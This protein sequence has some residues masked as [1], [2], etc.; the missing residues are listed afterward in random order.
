MIRKLDSHLINQIAAGEVI[1]RPVSVV[2]ELVENSID[3]GATRIQVNLDFE[4]WFSLEV[5][6]NGCWIDRGDLPLVFEKHATSK[7][8]SLEDLQQVLTFGFRGEAL[9]SIGSVSKT[10]VV[11]GTAHSKKVFALDS[12]NQK[13]EEVAGEVGTRVK[14]EDLFYNTPARLHYLKKEKT[15]YGHIVDYIEKIALT[16]PELSFE[17]QYNGKKVLFFWVKETLDARLYQIFG[18][19]IAEKALKI[20]MELSGLRISGR[21]SHPTQSFGNKNKQVLSVNTRIISSPIIYKALSD[22]YNRYIAPRTFPAYVLNIELDPT[23]IDVN[24]HPRKQELRFA[25][26]GGIFRLVYQSISQ[27]LEKVSLM[28]ENGYQTDDSLSFQS[29]QVSSLSSPTWEN[30]FTKKEDFYTG[31]WT[32]FKG[33][34]PYSIRTENPNQGKVFDSLAFS[35]EILRSNT[36]FL[37]SEESQDNYDLHETPLWRI[38]WQVHKSYILVETPDGMKLYDQ[39]ALAERVIFEKLKSQKQENKLQKLLIP[40]MI[41]LSPKEFSFLEEYQK[42]F[43][44]LGFE[45]ELLSSG[46]ISLLSIPSILSRERV[47]EIFSGILEDLIESFGKT[48]KSLEEVENKILAYTACR[49][50]VKFGDSLSLFEMH[51]LLQDAVSDYS[52]TC[53]HGRPVIWE[54]SLAELKKKYER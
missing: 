29:Q 47:R 22:A 16:Y 36:S 7:I 18:S 26:E 19:E 46:M 24:V 32:K 45:L 48:T 34:S 30:S 41:S 6:D 5:R 39:H 17:L 35:Q 2:K 54:V 31:S 10:R 4:A 38:I 20:D 33:Y 3:A 50:A 12:V 9:A 42:Q 14:V 11:S 40:E 51:G 15:E 21:V 27:A 49:S 23:Q 13:I 37:K 1:E 44:E 43:W 8:S 28:P 25:D 53:P 52:S